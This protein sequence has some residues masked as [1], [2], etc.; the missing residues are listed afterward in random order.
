[1]KANLSPSAQ[2]IELKQLDND[3]IEPPN[4]HSVKS[5]FRKILKFL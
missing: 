5:T 3:S 2:L 4:L 1:M